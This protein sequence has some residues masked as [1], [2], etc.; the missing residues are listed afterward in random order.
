MKIGLIVLGV[1]TLIAVP[2]LFLMFYGMREIKTLVINEVDLSKVA[3]GSYSGSY[4]KGRWTYDVEVAVKDHHIVSVKNT[5][6][7]MK[8]VK[9]WNDK[10]AAAIVS[11]QAI[12]VDVV[13]GATVNTKAFEKAIE[14]ALSTPTRR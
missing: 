11:K 6:A 9:D 8:A 5:N 3:D 2:M 12:K 1:I 4:H 10:A 13:S 14:V 7:K